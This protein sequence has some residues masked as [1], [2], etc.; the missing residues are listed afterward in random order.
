MTG[1]ASA[2]EARLW[3]TPASRPASAPHRPP[4]PDKPAQIS[5]DAWPSACP[6]TRRHRW[7]ISFQT[8]RL[9]RV[10]HHDRADGVSARA[11]AAAFRHRFLLLP[12]PMRAALLQRL[13]AGD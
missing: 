3:S 5:R 13:R 8:R 12:A 10:K 9:R 11:V 6:D 2:A 4:M 1:A 7:R